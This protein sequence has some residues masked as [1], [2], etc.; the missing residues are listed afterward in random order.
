MI[1]RKLL[2]SAAAVAL[3]AASG[4]LA[5]AAADEPFDWSGLYIGGHVG[6]GGANYDGVD[7]NS[8]CPGGS[9]SFAEDLD[10]NGIAG[11]IHGG[12][13]WQFDDRLSGDR[14]LV[15]GIEADATFSDW[16]DQEGTSSDNINGKVDLLA[17]VRARAGIALDDVLV[18]ASGGIALPRAGY[19]S[20]DST[21]GSVDFDD[22]GGVVGGGMAWA[23]TDTVSVRAEGLYYIFNEYKDTSSLH[24]D[25]DPGDFAEFQNAWVARIGVDI[26][27]GEMPGG[28]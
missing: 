14:A 8:E 28:Y 23:V 18:F 13:N 19:S 7:H 17:S 5:P 24:Y 11:G 25:N 16:T 21:L 4:T 3:V 12:I 6:S 20:F 9:C 26:K 15:L 22:V 27:L 2:C 1:Q 10:L